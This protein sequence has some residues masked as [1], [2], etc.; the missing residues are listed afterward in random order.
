[1]CGWI[2]KDTVKRKNGTHPT[3]DHNWEAQLRRRL[4]PFAA[5]GALLVGMLAPGPAEAQKSGGL[6]RIPASNSPASLSIHEESTRFAVTPA[7]G[8]FNNLVLFDQ[9]IAQNNFDTIRPELAE[10]WAWNEEGTALTFK[11][12]QGVKWHDGK[13]F[14]SADVKCT[15]DMLAGRSNEK[16]SINPRKP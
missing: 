2:N 11:L 16:L 4:F 9:H 8:V 14:T 1:M 12:R 10:S 5:A 7:M 15:W 13:P 3:R 6:L